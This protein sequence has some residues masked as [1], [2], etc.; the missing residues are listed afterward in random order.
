MGCWN[1][2]CG[3][4]NLHIT[5]GM[6]VYVFVLEKNKEYENC[7][8]TSLFS[9][10]LLPFEAK[11]NDYGGGEECHGVGLDLIIDGIRERLI[12]RDVGEN[13]Y[14]DIAVKRADFDVS[15]FFEATH[16][17]R[18]LIRDRYDSKPVP[19]YFTMFRKDIVD[20]IIENRVI[21]KYVGN[22][23]G[24]CGWNN[25]YVP[26]KFAD[27]V[28]SIR[29]LLDRVA[30]EESQRVFHADMAY[31]HREEFLAAEW[32]ADNYR[33]SRIVDITDLIRQTFAE[34][35][36]QALDRLESI[37]V[38][39]VKGVF[40]DSFMSE[41]RKTWIPGGHE[42]SQGY[43]GSALRLLGTAVNAALDRERAEEEEDYEDDD[44]LVICPTC[45]LEG[46]T[47]SCGL[48]NCGL[49]TGSVD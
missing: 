26:V 16:E 12:E 20:D 48:P 42:G 28:A 37:L 41:A 6:P 46:A 25:N 21:E 32:L 29:P 23:G 49:I 9:P 45:G 24:T 13:K 38:E 30:S 34:R 35:T 3:L 40:I 15:K 36:T 7:Y 5:A 11:Y 17:G 1:K 14:H 44:G 22:G 31:E 2:T 39:Y 18:L 47:T 8:T 27:I 4:S 43:S 19:V 10:L 33:F